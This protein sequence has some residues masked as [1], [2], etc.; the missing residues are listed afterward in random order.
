[1]VEFLLEFLQDQDDGYKKIS[2]WVNSKTDEGY[3]ALH[4]ASF[5]GN[6]VAFY[7]NYLGHN[8]TT[9]KTFRGYLLC[10]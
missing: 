2:E 6:I 8:K 4:F 10:E 7:F 9:G 5:R 1:M 3:S